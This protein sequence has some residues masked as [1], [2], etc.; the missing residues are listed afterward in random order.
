MAQKC[1]PFSSRIFEVLVA[2]LVVVLHG[3]SGGAVANTSSIPDIASPAAS[4]ALTPASPLSKAA[5]ASVPVLLRFE[6]PSVSASPAPAAT[7]LVPRGVARRKP[8]YISSSN[9]NITITVT[10]L[11]GAGTIFGPTGCTTGGCVVNFTALPGPNTIAFSLTDGSGNVLSSFS[12]I[13]VIQP[14]TLNTLNLTANPVVN[15]A[16]LSLFASTINAGTP[17]SDVLTVN[18][19]DKDGNTIVGSAN[20]VDV[21]GNP[22]ALTLATANVQNGGRG[23]V[24]IKG[25]SRLTAPAQAAIYAYYDG[26]WLDHSAISVASSSSAVTALTGTTL[27]TTPASVEYTGFSANFDPWEIT[28]G[29]DGN[30]WFTSGNKPRIGKMTLSGGINEYTAG[31]NAGASQGG[32]TAGP[33]GNVWFTEFNVPRLAKIT[34]AGAVTEFPTG[35]GASFTV[36]ITT[37]PDGNLWYTQQTPNAVGRITPGGTITPFTSGVTGNR[38]DGIS[39]GP[40]G[41]LWYTDDIS[42]KIGLMLPQGNATEF[43]YVDA[44]GATNQNNGIITGPDGN[45]WFISASEKKIGKSTISGSTSMYSAGLGASPVIWYIIPGPDGNLYFTDSGNRSIGKITTAG[46]I[47]EYG[48]GLPAG[49]QPIGL[50]VGRDGNIWFADYGHNSVGKFVW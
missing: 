25:P 33:D 45:L 29:P 36:D 24:T 11:G 22:V 4:P 46:A 40:D 1:S 50:V 6:P 26:G 20:F 23:T 27:T 42:K 44:S 28:S 49:S 35:S 21:N 18:A 13:Q 10:P 19:L 41:N 9:I 30:L 12:T 34:P 8:L 31:I 48:T 43:T 14:N 32:I 47:T 17:N 15:S 7:P 39:P 2:L 5:P 3:C 37:G 16:T 38:P